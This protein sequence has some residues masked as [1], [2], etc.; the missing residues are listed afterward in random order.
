MVN[1]RN[2]PLQ[3]PAPPEVCVT[4]LKATFFAARA[5]N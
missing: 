3:P 5:N 4:M 2:L 1:E